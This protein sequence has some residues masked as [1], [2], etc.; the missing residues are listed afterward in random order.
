MME[1]IFSKTSGLQSN[2]PEGILQSV[3]IEDVIEGKIEV[4]GRIQ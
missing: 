4:L 1:E 3:G 2:K